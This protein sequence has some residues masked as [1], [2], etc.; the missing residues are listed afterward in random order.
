MGS[1]VVRADEWSDVLAGEAE[2]RSIHAAIH[3]DDPVV[4]AGMVAMLQQCPEIRLAE[5]PETPGLSVLVICADAVDDEA[6]AAMRKW[7]RREGVR[8]VLVVGAIREAQLLD[9]IEHGVVAVVRR[10]EVSISGIVRAIRTAD[11]GAGELPA[12]LLGVLLAQLGQARRLSNRREGMV[13]PGFS[14]REIDV[15][16]LLAQGHDTREI[17]GRLNYSERTVKNVLHVLMMRL[18]LRNRAHAVAYAAQQ[19]YL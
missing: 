16:R 7:G 17:A 18:H 14:D 3:S 8:T 9:A 11:R 5:D 4:R 6:L 15:V 19:G 1:L 10:R 12:D 13:V 2:M